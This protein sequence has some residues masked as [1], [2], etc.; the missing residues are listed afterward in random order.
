MNSQDSSIMESINGSL[1]LKYKA[2]LT[3]S[4]MTV[5]LQVSCTMQDESLNASERSMAQG[6]GSGPGKEC[7]MFG[8]FLEGSR[9]S[10]SC[11]SGDIS[12][13][14]DGSLR[15]KPERTIGPG[16]SLSAPSRPADSGCSGRRYKP[17]LS[18]SCA[19]A[20]P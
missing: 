6:S 9:E 17:A 7:A 20:I 18:P 19:S 13:A 16:A 8:L 15:F 3:D 4:S 1:K 2:V 10:P 14:V 11:N 12:R 5:S